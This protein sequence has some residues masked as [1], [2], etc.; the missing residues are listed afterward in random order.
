MVMVVPVDTQVDEAQEVA[1]EHRNQWLQNIDAVP[2]R[3]RQF[4]DHDRDDDR[5]HTVAERLEPALSHF[6]RV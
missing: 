6:R 5:D 1:E 4:Q 2:M 3:H